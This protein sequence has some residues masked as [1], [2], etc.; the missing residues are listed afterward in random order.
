MIKAVIFDMDGILINSEPVWFK[1]RKDLF[2]PLNLEWTW[3]DQKNTMGVSTQ[4]WVDYMTKKA[5]GKLT[6]D[7]ILNG[8]VD[9]MVNYYEAGEVDAMPGA[10]DAV[11]YCA[12]KYKT[13]VASGSY[14]KLLYAAIE[15]K[16]W[17]KYFEE[18]LS[19]D[20]LERG[21]PAP[22]IYLEVIKRLEVKPEESV[23]IEDS[24]DGMRAG[25]AAGTN[26]IAVP[27]EGVKVP[28]EIK[29]KVAEVIPTLHEFSSAF[30][31]I[32]DSKK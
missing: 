29:D 26:I 3:E 15:S 7:E 31:R 14:K 20:D 9:R 2:E 12:G 13:G 1:A 4:T 27:S 11:K 10:D 19:S 30:E 28:G 18:I 24:A 23:I 21:K 25:V 32:K 17:K 5:D 8:I 16:G 6:P 22:D